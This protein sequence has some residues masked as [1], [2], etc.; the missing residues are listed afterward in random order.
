MELNNKN[1]PVDFWVT[2]NDHTATKGLVTKNSGFSLHAGVATKAHERD[3]L[4][5]VCRYC[6]GLNFLDTV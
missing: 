1:E 5:K 3:R 4:E 6:T 2:D